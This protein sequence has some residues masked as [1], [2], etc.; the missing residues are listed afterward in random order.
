MITTVNAFI[1]YYESVRRRTM[2]YLHAI[3]PEQID[4]SPQRGAFTCGDIARHLAATE[5][6]TVRAV[7][8]GDWPPY[9][10]HERD[11]APDLDRI[12]AH[13]EA[14]H[15]Q[16]IERLGMLPDAALAEIRVDVTGEERQVWRVLMAM[17][18]HEIHHRSELGCYLALMETEPPQLF[19]LDTNELIALTQHEAH[20][21]TPA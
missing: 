9:L 1:R 21:D 3:P 4:W 12:L 5:A 15:R 14:T 19:G 17:I 8:E 11:I 13:L 2:T 20:D 6:L 10:G 18:E 7:I 16:S